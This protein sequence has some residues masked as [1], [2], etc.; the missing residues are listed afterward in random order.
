[1]QRFI[2]RSMIHETYNDSLNRYNVSED[3]KTCQKVGQTS[4]NV[5]TVYRTVQRF[6][7]TL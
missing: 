3:Q 2:K 5:V 7:I 1:M 4:Q 6:C